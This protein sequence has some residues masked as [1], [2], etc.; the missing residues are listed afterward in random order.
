MYLLIL[1]ASGGG[2]SLDY[3]FT[4]HYVSINS[5]KLGEMFFEYEKF[6]SHYVSINSLL[7]ELRT[8]QIF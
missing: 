2:T 6:T 8:R 5:V 7:C 4:S 3:R 1:Y